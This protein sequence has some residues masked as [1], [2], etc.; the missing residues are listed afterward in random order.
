MHDGRGDAVQLDGLTQQA[1]TRLAQGERRL[2]IA[3]DRERLVAAPLVV[4]DVVGEG[5]AGGVRQPGRAAG[6]APVD[7]AQARNLR[8]RQVDVAIVE[9]A[10][11]EIVHVLGRQRIALEIADDRRHA[12]A[13]DG[14]DAAAALEAHDVAEAGEERVRCEVD[15]D[16]T[17][18]AGLVTFG[19][20][21]ATGD[22][23]PG[24]DRREIGGGKAF[25]LQVAHQCRRQRGWSEGGKRRARN[26]A[27]GQYSRGE[28]G[29]P[30]DPR[31][32]GNGDGKD[33]RHPSSM[34]RSA[35]CYC[36][37]ARGEA[38][39][40]VPSAVRLPIAALLV[41]FGCGVPAGA[42]QRTAPTRP[43]DAAALAA[44]DRYVHTIAPR[45][46]LIAVSRS[47]LADPRRWPVLQRVNR[48]RDPRRLRPG[49]TLDIPV[50]LLRR[51]PASAEVLWVRGSARVRRADGIDVVAL[52]GAT[53]D[54]GARVT[55][56]A[57]AAIGLR[58]TTGATITIGEGADVAFDE[59]R[60]VP[61]A[62]AARTRIDLRR[63]RLQNAVPA[64]AAPGQ[65]YEIRT[66]VITTAVRGTTFRVGVDDS[67]TAAV[68]EVTDGTV[69]VAR[70]A[71]SLDVAAGFGAIAREG[72]PL[73]PPRPLLPAAQVA[74]TAVQQRLPAR[75][76]WSPVPGATRYRAEL[77]AGAPAAAADDPLI[78]ERV[79]TAP[80][81][82]WPD[83]A[84]GRYRVVIR[85]IDAEGL[86]GA[87]AE[88]RLELDARPEPPIAQAPAL[89]A[90]VFGD[91]AAF[92]W[93]RPAGATGFDIELV[94]RT[95]NGGSAVAAARE[96][97]A[98]THFD[99]PLAPGRYA[100][101]V[102]SRATRADGS[103]DLGP[104]NDA[105]D[106]TLKAVPPAGPAASAD[107]ADRTS[108]ALRWAA[109]LPGDRYRV[110]LARDAVFTSPIADTVVGE[111][112]LATPRPEP[113]RYGVR[114]SIV[115]AEGTEG[116]FGPV[117]SFDIAPIKT[118]S[119][120]W[121]LEPIAVA[122]GLLI[123]M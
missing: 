108:L 3:I 81:V 112:A 14:V 42:Q 95:A 40:E 77:R 67:G 74:A 115:N 47:L 69:G 103:P 72:V 4:G 88:A 58:L 120:W 82:R 63:G 121:V 15:A 89:D 70:A 119:W 48:V 62:G 34:D 10:A 100:W 50:D 104:W 27:G 12:E 91:R 38:R 111:P 97:L 43:A 26:D 84:D 75:L 118:R 30:R 64:R 5:L 23:T 99:A 86:E 116:P 20:R 54:E 52:V 37:A 66:P 46:T 90:V 71:E 73:G 28:R 7:A 85:A 76:R 114:V 83:L 101:R 32:R 19:A 87:D 36:G 1:R 79:V 33:L 56:A 29:A 55:T 105:L 68:A 16:H 11:G 25:T 102:R 44:G 92:A 53:L 60:L 59:L 2:T 65:R 94:A 17:N 35:I 123:G 57:G 51:V 31:P 41:G 18:R 106:F 113:G 39:G 78:D 49:R 93:T 110:Q 80:E 117:Q 21:Q 24:D 109:G 122:V 96:A 8:R 45:D 61:A 6:A 22:D 9:G 107:A 13:A 98:D